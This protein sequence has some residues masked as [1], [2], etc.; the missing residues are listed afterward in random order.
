M[1]EKKEKHHLLRSLL[2]PIVQEWGYDAV[3]RC[4]ADLRSERAKDGVSSAAHDRR[5]RKESRRPTALEMVGRLDAAGARKESLRMLAERFD[6]KTFLPTVSDVRH[7]L[8]MR[9]Q[10]TGPVK[11]RQ[12]SFKKVLSV[13][14]GMADEELAILQGSGTHAGPTQ[15][16]PLSDA[17]KA[18]SAAV[19]NVDLPGKSL[20]DEESRNPHL[21]TNGDGSANS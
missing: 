19:R 7:F 12:D 11:Q 13:L 6:E 18:T 8:D 1:T 17:I 14:V 20:P 3:F 16:G 5:L 10:D 21:G 9:G 4:L 2:I 15:L